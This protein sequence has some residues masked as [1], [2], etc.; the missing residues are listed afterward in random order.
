VSSFDDDTDYPDRYWRGQ[1]PFVLTDA[2]RALRDKLLAEDNEK[3]AR[4]IAE[5][6]HRGL[7]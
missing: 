7:K 4:H 1:R 6:A 2:Q 3:L 5:L